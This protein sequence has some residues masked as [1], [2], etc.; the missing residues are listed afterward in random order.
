M[1]ARFQTLRG[2]H[3]VLPE[4]AAFYRLVENTFWEVATRHGFGEI[5]TPV[6]EQ[7][8]LFARSVG[9]AT[10]IVHKEMYSFRDRSDN[11]VSLRP[12]MTASVA[13]AYLEHG[14]HNQPQPLKL[15][16]I[17]N[18]YRYERPQ[19]G[20]YREFEQF[21]LEVFGSAEPAVD[22]ELILATWQ[23]YESLGLKDL[24][25]QINSLGTEASRQAIRQAITDTL[26][27]VA[28]TLSEDA[29]RQ[30]RDN[31][32]RILDSK[33]PQVQA[34]TANIP[35]LIDHLTDA[36]RDHFT[37]VLEYLDQ[38]GVAYELNPRLVR[39]FDYYTRT[40]F[41][42]WGE[43]GGQVAL[44]GGGRYDKLVSELGGPDT[45]AIGMAG[46]VERIVSLLKEG[47][48]RKPL[49]QDVQVFLIQL[50]NEA[51]KLSFELVDRLTRAGLGVASAPGKDSIRSQLKMADRAGAPL[52]LIIGQKEA[53]DGSGIIRDMISGMQE[54]VPLPDVVE[55]LLKRAPGVVKATKG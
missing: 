21:G 11:E 50:G 45:P 20:R 24:S 1:D 8:E 6:L 16:Y 46:G 23:T 12:E 42:I 10:D 17:A 33:D 18:N 55:H 41:E 35:P 30:L 13:R 51:R 28:S 36:D 19:A 26:A 5:R 53:L 7:T 3:D 34:A 39:G 47:H 37:A 25:V 14:L 9:E 54:T 22:A 31:P 32:L 29:Q 48:G 43:A 40:V 38:V 2:M 27:P 4:D 15:G 44:G 52:A 49:V